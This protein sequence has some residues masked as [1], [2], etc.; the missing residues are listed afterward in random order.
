MA[1][2]SSNRSQDAVD[3]SLLGQRVVIVGGT[4]GMGLGAVYAALDAG[5]EVIMAGRR[6]EAARKFM[7][8]HQLLLKHRVV[9]VTDEV[10]VREMFE[11]LGELDHLFVTA[12]PPPGS[13]GRLLEQNVASAQEYMNGKFFGSWTCARYAAPKMRVGGS[14]TFLTGCA[15]IRPRPGLAMVTATFAALEAL[16]GALALEL[17]PL[18][19]NAIR[20][21]IVNSE[22]WGFLDNATREKVFQKT[23]DTFPVRRVGAIEDIGRAAVFLMT[24]PYITGAVL[25]VSGG[26]TLVSLDV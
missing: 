5:A 3:Q 22:M 10:A 6:A 8:G 19:V 11:D 26:E 17:G 21:G 15:A 13:W 14:I 23:R 12:A 24:S 7:H 2:I 20:P 16:S 18:R 25:E 4:S 9:D 1:N